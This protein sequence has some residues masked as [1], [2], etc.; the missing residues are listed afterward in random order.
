MR[1][2][3]LLFIACLASVCMLQA[4]MPQDTTVYKYMVAQPQGKMFSEK[5]KLKI[6]DGIKVEIVKDDNGKVINFTSYA[7]ALMYITSQ[8]WKLVSTYSMA[9]GD[10]Y[11]A[12]SDSETLT[13]WVFR[14]PSTKEEVQ[15]IIDKSVNK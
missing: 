15:A 10:V 14:K 3:L 9:D 6:D 2:C 4:Q 8:G 11:N 5:C 1:R 7:A 13:Y 12:F